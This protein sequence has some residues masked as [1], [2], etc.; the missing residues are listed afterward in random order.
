MVDLYQ[1]AQP[2]L[3]A[4]T[5]CLSS[6]E[7]YIVGTTGSFPQQQALLVKILHASPGL[8]QAILHSIPGAAKRCRTG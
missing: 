2:G 7:E 8:L 1:L 3:A 6:Q 5:A 4:G